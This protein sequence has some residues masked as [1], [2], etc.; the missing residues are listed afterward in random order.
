MWRISH[1]LGWEGGAMKCPDN[2]SLTPPD[3]GWL[4]YSS[5]KGWI[6]DS[7]L[8]VSTTPYSWCPELTVGIAGAAGERWPGY[9]GKYL[10]TSRNSCGMMVRGG[11]QGGGVC[12]L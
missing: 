1:T 2:G 12:N 6:P 7:T 9:Q 10:A 8:R 3:Q 11:P 5:A 4:V